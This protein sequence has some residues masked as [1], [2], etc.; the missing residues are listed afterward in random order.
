MNDSRF[1]LKKLSQHYENTY[2]KHGF[3]SIGADWGDEKKHDLRLISMLNILNI[4]NLSGTSMLD[5]GCGYGRLYSLIM[6]EFPK[7][8][9][10][11]TGIDPCE[12]V[13]KFAQSSL[14]P[15]AK[16]ICGDIQSF[17]NINK[18][19]TIFCCGV[20]TK[21]ANMNDSEMYELLSRLFSM[22][23]K[24]GS[25]NVCFNTMSPF[26]DRED[27]EIFYPK[28]NNIITLINQYF[29]F[30]VCDFILTNSHL[31]YEMIWRFSIEKP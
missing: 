20:F 16:F 29:G 26:C 6:T 7:I 8:S 2:Q 15:S 13:I 27:H 23:N 18:F 28:A 31:K 5:V 11:Y 3:N 1:N 10:D 21:K 22:A 30:K 9:I 4:N 12:K 24:A 14:G 25:S 17:T 19:D